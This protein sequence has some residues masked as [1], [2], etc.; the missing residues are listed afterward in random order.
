MKADRRHRADK[1]PRQLDSIET[2]VEVMK[3]L[4]GSPQDVD[5][6]GIVRQ[7]DE[8][9]AEEQPLDLFRFP[10]VN[11]P[12]H[13]VEDAEFA[14]PVAASSPHGAAY[15]EEEIDDDA[16]ISLSRFS[17]GVL[18]CE[19]IVAIGAFSAV[20]IWLNAQDGARLTKVPSEATA[21]SM[22]SSPAS[23]AI[24]FLPKGPDVAATAGIPPPREISREAIQLPLPANPMPLRPSPQVVEAAASN[25][26]PPART[27]PVPAPQP[28]IALAPLPE[29]VQPPPPASLAP[30]AKT[31]SETESRPAKAAPPEEPLKVAD[32]PIAGPPEVAQPTLPAATLPAPEIINVPF[33]PNVGQALSNAAAERFAELASSLA[34]E[35]KAALDRERERAEAL[36]HELAM[37]RQ[38]LGSLRQKEEEKQA[39]TRTSRELWASLSTLPLPRGDE[40]PVGAVQEGAVPPPVAAETSTP[41]PPQKKDE[42]LVEVAQSS[43]VETTGTPLLLGVAPPLFAAPLEPAPPATAPAPP[44]PAAAAAPVSPAPPAA[45]PAAPTPPVAAAAAAAAPTPPAPAAAAAAA[46]TP[47]A[48]AAAAAAAPV[49]PAPPAAAPAPTAATPAPPAAAPVATAPPQP[50]PMALSPTSEKRLIERAETLLRDL[51]IS[52]A[53]LVLERALDAGSSRAAFL[54]AQTYDPK[55]LVQWRVRGAVPDTARA[56]DLY[57]RALAAGIAEAGARAAE[58]RAEPR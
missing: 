11:V 28:V 8:T 5:A 10:E 9:S 37:A 22:R 7:H 45:A 24:A 12:E 51:D 18:A 26:P 58:L 25:L 35:R 14:D 15:D 16:G 53:R 33:P 21:F 48:P 43:K 44:A 55:M 39:D 3:K 17:L 27:D 31:A 54:L 38:E 47:P 57:G 6:A 4:A 41:A 30:P 32:I 34:A 13:P 19:S 50:A 49:S 56:R 20:A 29:V 52:G 40:P 1:G 36:A 42:P 23:G 2:A 46:P